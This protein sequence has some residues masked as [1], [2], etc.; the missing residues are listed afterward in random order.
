MTKVVFPVKQVKKST[1]HIVLF[2]LGEDFSLA[3]LSSIDVTNSILL[4]TKPFICLHEI[5][6]H[7]LLK[8]TV[9]YLG[10]FFSKERILPS[11]YLS[12]IKEGS[13]CRK[14]LLPEW[15]ALSFK[16]AL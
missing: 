4:I 16:K 13:V 3:P 6:M 12:P 7:F 2:R 10:L 11:K 8:K 5:K 1:K 15:A 9:H 14:D